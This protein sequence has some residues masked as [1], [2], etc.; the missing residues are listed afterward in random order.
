MTETCGCKGVRYCSAC[1]DTP[2][3]QAL[4]VAD[5]S[6]RLGMFANIY[7]RCNNCE[8]AFA[9][10]RN[11]YDLLNVV[12]VDRLASSNCQDH[13]ATDLVSRA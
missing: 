4:R 11:A 5:D 13:R 6:E 12:T 1:V 3:V 9:Y 7:V 8:R 2:R 10:D